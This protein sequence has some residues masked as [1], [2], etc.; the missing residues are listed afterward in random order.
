MPA[1]AHIV[2]TSLSGDCPSSDGPPKILIVDDD[3]ML[4]RGMQRVLVAR[5]YE[6]IACNDGAEALTHIA[7]SDL[8]AVVSDLAM[9]NMGGVELLRAVRAHGLDVPV[10]LATG[11]P[12]IDSA[13]AAVEHGAFK[14]LMKPVAIEELEATVAKAVRLHRLARI[15]RETMSALS[16]EAET[17][18]SRLG[19][20][21]DNALR[22][23]WPAFQPIVRASDGSLFGYEALLRSDEPALPSAPAVL[24]AAERLNALWKLGRTVRE[25]ATDVLATADDALHLFLN[26]HPRD[27]QDPLLLETVERHPELAARIVFEVTER[28]QLGEASETRRHITELRRKGFRIAIDDLGAGYSG[29]TSFVQ[30]EPEFVKLDMS[31]VRDINTIRVKQRLIRSITDVCKDL[32]ILVVGEGVETAE[33]R[34][35]LIELGCE[36][37]QGYRF[38]K[39]QRELLQPTW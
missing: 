36:L 16:T 33:E 6:V 7:R 11:E 26:L 12:S 39:P 19:R 14:Y 23:L 34:D 18:S 22:L 8:D 21:F 27:L 25:R 32:G 9:P 17:E 31:L 35:T 2:E 24:E 13:V 5:G 28:G 4:L 1:L 29:L 15:Q 30:L 20:N 10:I 3:R 37:L 38:G